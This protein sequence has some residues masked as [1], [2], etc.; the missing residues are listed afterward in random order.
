[1][2]AS[3]VRSQRLFAQHTGLTRKLL[4]VVDYLFCERRNNV[5]TEGFRN[6]AYTVKCRSVRFRCKAALLASQVALPC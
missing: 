1:M 6:S 3:Y 2:T 4:T 5:G